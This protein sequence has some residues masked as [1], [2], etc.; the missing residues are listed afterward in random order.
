LTNALAA[1]S[2]TFKVSL[3][4]YVKWLFDRAKEYP[5]NIPHYICILKKVLSSLDSDRKRKLNDR[6]SSETIIP[7]LLN[8]LETLSEAIVIEDIL[9][10]LATLLQLY[11]NSVHEHFKRLI[12]ILVGFMVDPS[13]TQKVRQLFH[14]IF[15]LIR[16]HR[17]LSFVCI[18]DGKWD[19]CS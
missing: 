12:R 14:S 5:D 15:R 4:G 18:V 1:I 10:C 3:V 19:V 7:F 9:E 13:V 6:V 11:P 2:Y 8:S 16:F 17:I